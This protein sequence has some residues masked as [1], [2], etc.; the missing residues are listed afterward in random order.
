MGCVPVVQVS[1]AGRAA[2]GCPGGGRRLRSRPQRRAGG[3]M[4]PRRPWIAP[5]TTIALILRCSREMRCNATSGAGRSRAPAL[6]Q[7]LRGLEEAS[8]QVAN[9][10]GLSGASAAMAQALSLPSC[11]HH[12]HRRGPSAA[13]L[14]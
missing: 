13:N 10:C 4:D 9:T 5:H 8:R 6:L 11:T 1:R 14:L 7:E 2:G 3:R 12:H